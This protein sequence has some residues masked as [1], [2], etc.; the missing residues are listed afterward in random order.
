MLSGLLL[1]VGKQA[2]SALCII[3]CAAFMMATKDNIK[4]KSDVAAITREEKDRPENFCRD[5]SLI[6]CALILLGGM[7][8]NPLSDFK[9]TP[10]AEPIEEKAEGDSKKNK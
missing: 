1:L 8:S 10:E 6:G 5:I 4:I 2:F 9:V 7:A 3:I